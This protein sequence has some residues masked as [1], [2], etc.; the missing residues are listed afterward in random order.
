MK[1]IVYVDNVECKSIFLQT[2][3]ASTERS[4]GHPNLILP[5][6]FLHLLFRVKNKKKRF[7]GYVQKNATSKNNTTTY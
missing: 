3:L 7:V 1:I 6:R 2:H 5:G 4:Y